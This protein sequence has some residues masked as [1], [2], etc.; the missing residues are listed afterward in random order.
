MLND[1]QSS[2]NNDGEQ[3]LNDALAGIDRAYAK[4]ETIVNRRL[5][6]IAAKSGKSSS[7]SGRK[8]AILRSGLQGLEHIITTSQQ[9]S[10]TVFNPNS[11][12]TNNFP[13]S[14]GQWLVDLVAQISRSQSRN[15]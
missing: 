13:A 7:Q 2:T 11:Q 9:S 10:S 15:S 5:R 3:A 4:L 6:S 8:N 1:D 14:S 12:K